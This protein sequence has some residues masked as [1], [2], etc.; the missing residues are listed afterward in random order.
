MRLW[1]A[2]HADELRVREGAR[3]F[4]D[5]QR[6]VRNARAYVAM[7]VR[8]GRIKPGSCEICSDRHVSPDWDDPRKP[9]AVRW[10]CREH[11]QEHV[12]DVAAARQGLEALRREFAAIADLPADVQAKLHKAALLGLDGNGAEPGT[13]RYRIALQLA[14]RDLRNAE[15]MYG[16]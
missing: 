15:P 11:R 12:A 1:R 9:L 13:F 16:A 10:F 6:L 14:Y 2:E 3:T 5:E 8:R 7:Y 4:T